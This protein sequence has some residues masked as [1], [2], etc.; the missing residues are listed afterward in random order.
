[1]IFAAPR[2]FSHRDGSLFRDMPA[3]RRIESMIG[4]A[5]GMN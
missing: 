1:M 4:G 5:G 2:S 3:H